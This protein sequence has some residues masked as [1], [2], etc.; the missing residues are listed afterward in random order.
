M[1]HPILKMGDPRL[2]RVA[3]PVD[4]FDT[5]EL[6]ALIDAVLSMEYERVICVFQPHTF[7]RT[8]ALFSDFVQ[9]LSRVDLPYLAEIYA[10]REKNTVGISSSDLA[11]EIPNAMYFP[12]FTE[13][14]EQLRRIARPGDIILTVGAGDIFKIGEDLLR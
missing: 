10:A 8:K 5:P 12:T 13:I 1:I 2:L 9:E 11:R 7:T 4:R 3:P 14:E 6:H